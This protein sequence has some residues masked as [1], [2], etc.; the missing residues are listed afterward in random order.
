MCGERCTR[1][2][3]PELEDKVRISTDQEGADQSLLSKGNDAF[4]V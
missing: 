2:S 1:Y 3:S 4:Q